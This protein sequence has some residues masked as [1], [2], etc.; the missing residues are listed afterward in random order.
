MFERG[1]EGN[2]KTQVPTPNL[3]HPPR[4]AYYFGGEK[5]LLPMDV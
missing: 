4:W 3:G 1:K 2:P 5:P